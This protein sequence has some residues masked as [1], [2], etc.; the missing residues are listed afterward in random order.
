MFRWWLQRALPLCRTDSVCWKSFYEPIA[1]EN[2]GTLWTLLT[3][4]QG[5]AMSR[6]RAE[7]EH[8]RRNR[9]TLKKARPRQV[10]MCSFSLSLPRQVL[11]AYILPVIFVEDWKDLVEFVAKEVGHESA[12][13]FYDNQFKKP[14][15][16]SRRPSRN[17]PAKLNC[18]PIYTGDYDRMFS[19][20]GSVNAIDLS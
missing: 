17:R 3:Y 9:T 16:S 7:E 12:V 10:P 6:S 8:P 1:L 14:L 4:K 18:W 13:L 19:N 15:T 20:V 2:T 11:H 5:V